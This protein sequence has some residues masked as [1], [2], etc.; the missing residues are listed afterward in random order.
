MKNEIKIVICGKEYKL[1]TAE[2]PNYVFALARALEGK[3]NEIS[4]NGA[5]PYSAAIMVAL[6]IL[7]DLNKANKRLDDIRSQAKEYVS[8]AG[9]VRME[10]DTAVKEMEILKAKVAQLENIV[11]MQR[12]K[13][14]A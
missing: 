7:D 2:S 11:K 5:S 4:S 13:D 14:N 8:E 10:R 1:K 9:K 6:T 3:I 12:S